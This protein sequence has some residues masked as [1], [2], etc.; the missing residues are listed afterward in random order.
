MI[1]VYYAGG[2]MDDAERAGRICGGIRSGKDV[3]MMVVV[4]V[5][6]AAVK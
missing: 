5:T 1:F 6:A 2:D 4:V 3:V